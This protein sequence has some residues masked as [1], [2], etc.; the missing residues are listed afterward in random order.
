MYFASSEARTEG[1]R[2]GSDFLRR[3][4]VEGPI[5][6]RRLSSGSA[7]KQVRNLLV[8]LEQTGPKMKKD[9][10]LEIYDVYKR[11]M[12]GIG[13]ASSAARKDGHEATKEKWAS[14][15]VEF[16]ALRTRLYA[17]EDAVRYLNSYHGGSP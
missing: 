12:V 5:I 4:Q 7:L 3:G 8:E 15:T 10:F 14:V 11:L 9:E 6:E 16:V 17:V 1:R 2:T 13:H